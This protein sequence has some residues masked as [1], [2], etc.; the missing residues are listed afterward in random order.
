MERTSD[1][2]VENALYK[3]ETKATK[4]VCDYPQQFEP[5]CIGAEM[6]ISGG[7][8][9]PCYDYFFE[10]KDYI[11]CQSYSAWS[12]PQLLVLDRNNMIM[13]D[14]VINDGTHV[15]YA[16]QMFEHSFYNHFSVNR[17]MLV[18]KE[19]LDSILYKIMV[20]DLRLFG[21][22]MIYKAIV[23]ESKRHVMLT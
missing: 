11:V 17:K 7:L 15:E 14:T 1:I 13:A 20:G 23:E 12:F 3:A 18:S 2:H 19:L 21:K 9:Y 16:E 4:L 22:D 5:K 8:W 10:S 6:R